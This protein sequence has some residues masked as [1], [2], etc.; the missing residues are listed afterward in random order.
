[1]L[2]AQKEHDW[3][4]EVSQKH[5]KNI[6]ADK[7]LVPG[8][9][10]M[11][12]QPFLTVPMGKYANAVCHKCLA[13]LPGKKLGENGVGNPCLPRYCEGCKEKHDHELDVK[14]AGVRIKMAEIAK[15]HTIDPTMLHIITLLDL[16][17][18]G[19]KVAVPLE[20]A[21][22]GKGY[23]NEQASI[24]CTV[25]DFDALTNV[26]DRKPEAWRKKVGPAV[27]TLHKEL[28]TLAESLSGYAP[29][30]L[31]TM[32]ADAAKIS[33]HVQSISSPRAGTPETGVGIFPG[34]SQFQQCCAPNALFLSIGNKLFVRAI[35]PIAKG[36]EINVSFANI[37]DTR[38]N[39]KAFL[40]A[41]RH[42]V[43]TCPR[44][45]HPL[46]ESIDR[47]IEGVVCLDCRADVV[48]PLEPGEENDKATE[49]YK[50]RLKEDREYH[51]KIMARRARKGKGS[52]DAQELLDDEDIV[53][54]EGVVFWR[55]CSCGSVEPAHTVKQDGPGDI[56]AQANRLLQQGTTL[57]S[58]RHPELSAQGETMLNTLASGLLEGRLPPYHIKVLEALP[59][60]ININ[61][62]KGEAVKV[63]N[64]AIQLW[65]TER[66]LV[67][68]RPTTQQ[69]QCLE[70]VIDAA[71][72]KASNASSNVIKR[73]FAKRVKQAE[74]QLKETRRILLGM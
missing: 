33:M 15:E 47:L 71:E 7:D 35:V 2:E 22:T 68:E 3:H 59:P 36:S 61:M 21:Q 49:E 10:V 28:Q 52:K 40:E 9:L 12:E 39:R 69:L 32:Q 14:L 74:V 70:A 5:V 43:C 44:C 1:M 13:V 29:S 63:L 34:L 26:W 65:D 20:K 23:A 54:P 37:A 27:R 31:T 57:I 53:V 16:Q 41:E 25:A 24:A 19:F 42:I 4:I 50:Q 58:L 11:V 18:S 51:A 67:E 55:C 56:I 60:L 48:L 62:K 66:Q 17:R 30:S 73:Q 72:H 46:E 64:Y 38:A 45:Q 6:V 8:D